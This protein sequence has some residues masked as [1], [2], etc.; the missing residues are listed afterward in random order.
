MSLRLNVSWRQIVKWVVI[1]I[2]TILLAV[3]FI[4]VAVW[5]DSYYREKE[6]SERDVVENEVA[7]IP[8][9]EEILDEEEPTDWI[10]APFAFSMV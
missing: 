8:E 2:A 9:P 4:R 1:A 5:E 3:F 10:D 6:G 7:I